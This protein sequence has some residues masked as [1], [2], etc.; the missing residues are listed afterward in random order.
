MNTSTVWKWTSF[1]WNVGRVSA[2]KSQQ[3]QLMSPDASRTNLFVTYMLNLVPRHWQTDREVRP[4]ATFVSQQHAAH[5]QTWRPRYQSHSA[6]KTFELDVIRLL[7]DADKIGVD[8]CATFI[9]LYE[10]SASLIRVKSDKTSAIFCSQSTRTCW[11]GPRRGRGIGQSRA[12]S[13]RCNLS[14]IS[15]GYCCKLY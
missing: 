13:L 12:V 14:A 2:S 15:V 6:H 5:S 4:R 7:L 9:R 8:W 3:L 11:C 10:L 1:W